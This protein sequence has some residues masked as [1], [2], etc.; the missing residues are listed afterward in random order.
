[1]G[2]HFFTFKQEL[3]SNQEYLIQGHTVI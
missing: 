3:Q 2:V 1:L